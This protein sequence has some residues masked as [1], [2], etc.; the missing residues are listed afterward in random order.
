MKRLQTGVAPRGSL[1]ALFYRDNGNIDIELIA[2]IW[3]RSVSSLRKMKPLIG[4]ER[5]SS[6]S[7]TERFHA[8]ASLAEDRSMR[9]RWFDD[10]EA[11]KK[12]IVPSFPLLA[13][14]YV[15][16]I[17]PELDVHSEEMSRAFKKAPY[18]K[19]F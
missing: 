15:L 19:L 4:P 5:F 8:L 17:A 7:D 14:R 16:Q 11:G 10:H 9:K 6:G 13:Q 12:D 1:P 18:G 2:D 3:N